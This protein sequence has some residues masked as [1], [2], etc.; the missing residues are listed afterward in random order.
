MGTGPDLE[1]LT[2]VLT[3]TPLDVI[4]SGGVGSLEHIREL[5]Q[6][7]VGG[8]RPEGVIVGKAI[9]DGAVDVSAAIEA[10]ARS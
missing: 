8:R 3:S 7:E 4:A 2:A 10:L 1:G 6:L 5:A 9:H